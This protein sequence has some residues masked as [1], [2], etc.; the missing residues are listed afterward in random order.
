MQ[1]G[2]RA[3]PLEMM[4]WIMARAAGTEHWQLHREFKNEV[5]LVQDAPDEGGFLVM[6]TSAHD[7]MQPEA[8]GWGRCTGMEDPNWFIFND[9]P[10]DVERHEMGPRGL[11]A[12]SPNYRCA[13]MWPEIAAS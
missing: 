10:V 6:H 2:V 12:K 7:S 5:H 13:S 8:W 1:R 4:A 3:R 11:A 9:D